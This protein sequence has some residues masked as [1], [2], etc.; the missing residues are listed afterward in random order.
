MMTDEDFEIY[1]NNDTIN[2]GKKRNMNTITNDRIKL[3]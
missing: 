1:N 3:P 2:F